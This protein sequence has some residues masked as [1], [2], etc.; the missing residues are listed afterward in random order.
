[1]HVTV[2]AI[3]ALLHI[4]LFLFLTGLVISLFAIHHTVAY[5]AF[6]ATAVCSLAYTA[7]TVMPVVYHNSPY[8][9]PFSTPAW[10][11]SRKT[12]VA[13]L[14]A[15]DWVVNLFRQYKGKFARW[16]SAARNM[17]IP[18]LPDKVSSYKPLLSTN[19]TRAVYEAAFRPNP[20]RDAQALGW[21]LDRLDEEGELVKFAAGIPGFSR[22][23]K[24]KETAAILEMTPAQSKLHRDLDQHITFLLIRSLRPGLLRD[25]KILPESVREQRVKI[26]LEALYY[27]PHAIEKILNRVV[28]DC[29]DRKVVVGL[30]PVVK[31]VESW[32]VAERL[33]GATTSLVNP[34][35]KIVG[36]CMVAVI[37]SQPPVAKQSLSIL[38]RHLK[39][40]DTGLNRYLDPFDSLLLK[41]LNHFL[42]NTAQG[43]IDDADKQH[44]INIVLLTVRLAKRLKFEHAAQELRDQFERLR[45]WI[46]QHATG[47][48]GKARENAEKLLSELSSLTTGPPP[49][50]PIA[51]GT[52]VI[53]HTCAPDTA[54]TPTFACHAT[55]PPGE[56]REN[57]EK[58]LSELSSPTTGRRRRPPPPI[59]IT[60]RNAVSAHIQPTD[61][62]DTATTP[63]SARHA[64]GN[65]EENAEKSLSELSSPTTGRLRR[66]PPPVPVRAHIKPTDV[67]DTAATPTSA[68][69]ATGPPGNAEGNAEIPEKS[70]SELSGPTTG[71]R[72]RRPP[73][74]IPITSRNAVR[75][76]IQPT[77]A[78]DTSATP[79]SAR[80][81]QTPQS[82]SVQQPVSHV[83]NDAYILITSIPMS[84]D[85]ISP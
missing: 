16:R 5:I 19:M 20:Q 54:A 66:P 41:N 47:P 24:V 72:R 28:E 10:Y 40:N 38:M 62:P 67:P 76:H 3:P 23:I 43:V 53:A 65:A 14:N 8:T 80:A 4:S 31:S 84:Q 13:V 1:M 69:H 9:S 33:S 64:P 74:P 50:V 46:Q 22:S 77:D 49:P 55:G 35:V 45:T 57:A 27:L 81:A 30:S 52:A 83:P 75:A 12:A 11:I 82:L 15:V 2:E 58:S 26:C 44:H 63:T 56:A 71:R 17:T 68:R 79:T 61:A 39:I 48:P 70:L 78:P 18:S 51:S 25:P 85:D 42:I 7:I 60:S 73:P 34:A 32:L 36:Q 21:T 6:S 37:A 29:D 59:P